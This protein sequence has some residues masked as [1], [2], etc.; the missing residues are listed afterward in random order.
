MENRI[1]QNKKLIEDGMTIM[2]NLD[3]VLYLAGGNYSI[4]ELKKIS[5][6]DFLAIISTNNIKFIYEGN[7]E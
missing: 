1:N 4:E 2:K 5:V 6:F 3:D 7:K